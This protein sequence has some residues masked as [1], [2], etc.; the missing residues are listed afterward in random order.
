VYKQFKLDE[1]WDSEHNKKLVRQMPRFTCRFAAPR[2]RAKPLNQAVR[3]KDALFT[4]KGG[5]GGNG[6]GGGGWNRVRTGVQIPR[7]ARMRNTALVGSEAGTP[8]I[9]SSN[10][11]D[12]DHF[13]EKAPLPG[14]GGMFDGDFHIAGSATAPV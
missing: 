14:L 5:W 11:G 13:N 1:P 6:G 3:W 10:R 8:V 9:W 12:P 2:K 4:E 7:R